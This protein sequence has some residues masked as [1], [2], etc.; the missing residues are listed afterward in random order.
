MGDQ[1]H[2]SQ[3]I[4]CTLHKCVKKRRFPGALGL[5]LSHGN[6]RSMRRCFHPEEIKQLR[7]LIP[8]P[9]PLPQPL[10]II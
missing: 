1:L 6:R 5:G 9:P 3:V 2:A 8:P 10:Q 7:R 4:S